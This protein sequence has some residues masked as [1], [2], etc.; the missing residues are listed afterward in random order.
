[1]ITERE[2]TNVHLTTTR[3]HQRLARRYRR[4][5]LADTIEPLI[6]ALAAKRD[7]AEDKA[8]ETQAAYDSVLAADADL[9]DAVRNLFNAAEQHDRDAQN[10]AT[11]ALLTLFPTGGFSDLIDEPLAQEPASVDALATRLDSLGATS[12]LAPHAA[13]LRTAAQ[14]VRD[15]LKAQ[16]DAIRIEKSADA[17]EEIA[18]GGLRRQYEANYLSARGQWGKPFAERLFPRLYPAKEKGAAKAETPAK[19]V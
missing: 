4:E 6:A 5:A 17:E 8:F 19:P 10:A 18:Q 14:A 13:K 11:P 3:R 2:S 15:A 9:D 12:T 1:M 16:D 7:T